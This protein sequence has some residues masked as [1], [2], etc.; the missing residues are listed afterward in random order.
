MHAGNSCIKQ[1]ILFTKNVKLGSLNVRGLNDHKKRKSVFQ[2]FRDQKL[3]ICFIQETHV[4]S[5]K[6]KNDWEKQ[7][8]GTMISANGESNARGTAILINPRLECE[9]IDTTIDDEGRLVCVHA[10]INGKKTVLCN[11]YAPNEDSPEFFD[12]II[13]VIEKYDDRDAVIIGGDFNLVLDP[14][15]DRLHSLHN[16]SNSHKLL[17]NYMTNNGICDIWRIRNPEAKRFTWFRDKGG[18]NRKDISASR[19]D[20]FLINDAMQ[21]SVSDCNIEYGFKSDHSLINISIN[22]DAFRRG[23]GTWKLNNNLLLDNNYVGIINDTIDVTMEEA[24][25]LDPH[26]I[27]SLIKINCAKVSKE[28]SKEIAQKAR[29]EMTNLIDLRESLVYDRVRNP[30]NDDIQRSLRQVNEQINIHEIKKV[31]SALF[32]SK[33]NWI[34]SG[35]KMTKMFF[36]LEKDRYLE[37]NMKCIITDCGRHITDQ[38]SILAEQTKF[39]KN[40]YA[41]DEKI[42]FKLTRNQNERYLSEEDRAMCDSELQIGELFDAIMTLKSNKS[43]GGDGLTVEFYKKFYKKIAKPLYNMC[44]HS[45]KKDILPLST[46]RGVISL[47]PKPRKDARYI[48]NKRGLTLLNV[49]YKILAKA[50]D[51]R[52]RLTLPSIIS[53]DQNGFIKNRSICMNLRKN[54]DV[55]QY[56]KDEKVA[57][58]ILSIDMNKCFD[59]VSY[60]AIFGALDYYNYGPSFIK[61]VKLFYNQF[62]VCTQNFGELSEFFEKGRSINQGCIISPGIFLLTSEILASK[63]KLNN[64]IKGIKINN[65]EYLISQFADDMDIYIPY[66]KVILNEVLDSLADIETHTGLQVSYDKTSLY[67]IGSIADSQA[68][69]YTKRKINWQNGSINTLGVDL[70]NNQDDLHNNYDKLIQKIECVAESWYYRN[71]T[72]IGKILVV[73]AL[74]NSMFVY[75]MQILPMLRPHQCQKVD[76]IILKFLW[77]EKRPKIALNVLRKDKCQGGLGLADLNNKQKALQIK[78]VN[79]AKEHPQMGNLASYFLGKHYHEGLVWSYNINSKDID[80]TF[81]RNFWSEVLKA[82]SLVHYHTPQNYVNICN[83]YVFYNSDIRSGDRI[84]TPHKKISTKLRIKDLLNNDDS[85]KK[86]I[87][88]SMWQLNWLEYQKIINAIPTYWKTILKAGPTLELNDEDYVD[89]EDLLQ[90]PN[91][92]KNCYKLLNNDDTVLITT[93]RIWSKRIVDF[94]IHEHLKSFKNIYQITNVTKLRNFQYRLL[95]N[96]IFCNDILYYW[97]LKDNQKCDFCKITKQSIVHLLHECPIV[98]S[99]WKELRIW[100]NQ[101]GIDTEFSLKNILYNKVS[102]YGIA[103]FI[104]LIT[105]FTIYRS[106]CEGTTPQRQL[107]IQRNQNNKTNRIL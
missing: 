73:N 51:N 71:L 58:L 23:P 36:S 10:N 6:N 53:P 9:V 42:Q 12:Q 26:E 91:L 54:L 98:N 106:K 45:Y 85:F 97:K 93:G 64:K 11:I 50:L 49:D 79:Y 15:I 2:F 3:D 39:Y 20:M 40:L 57:A 30:A 41:K 67:R 61:W 34:D 7:W 87:D 99:I 27:W 74:M 89:T 55:I 8:K 102:E 5:M 105:K 16:N 104:T 52:L 56:C 19:I 63:L 13:K 107:Y 14:S 44:I 101:T 48:K 86:H 37:K 90:K 31:E 84:L 96:K 24:P 17:S 60:S 21:D 88:M 33:C 4:G 35:E 29:D 75:R 38:K 59:R 100:F 82:W 92:T 47:L 18:R 76:E 62:S 80:K 77:K 70:Y 68:K 69:L 28:Y 25:L 46:R 72:W 95:V 1:K 94:D 81:K 83:Q 66:D 32:R 78:W 103:N 65:M 43:P 22:L